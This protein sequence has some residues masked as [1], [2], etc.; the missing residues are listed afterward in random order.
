MTQFCYSSLGQKALTISGIGELMDDL[1]QA[2]TVR[3]DLLMLGGGNPAHIPEMEKVFRES[4]EDI[5]RKPGTYERCV[6]DYDG[7]RG[8]PAFLT[9]LAK[10][11]KTQY[12]WAIGPENIALTN[13]SQ[14]AFYVL[15]S[16]FAGHFADGSFHKILLPLAPEYIGYADIGFAPRQSLFAS[17]RPRME[18]LDNRQFKYHID[19]DT[20]SIGPEIGAVCVSRPT[21]P[22]GNVLTD[23]EI[24]RLRTMTRAAGVPLIIDNA[25]GLPFPG[26]LFEPATLSW[27]ENVI[28]CMSL[29]KLGLPAARTGIVVASPEVIRAISE[30]TAVMS[31]APG[32]IGPALALNL[33]QSRRI[34][35]LSQ[36]IVR[37]FYYQRMQDAVGLLRDKLDGID[38]CMHKPEGAIFLWLWFKNLPIPS[39]QLYQRL[40]QCGVLVISGHYF[41]P[42]L[43]HDDWPHKY[44]CIRITYSQ[45]ESVVQKGIQIIADEI[46]A[47]YAGA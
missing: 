22:T 17:I 35:E 24:A 23:D 2:M 6:G 37:P 9:A 20:L 18:F 43:E 26:I 39:A 12:G 27:D 13:G 19:F 3:P 33:I 10:L 31:L 36:T 11:L 16:L 32:S 8:S 29:S 42:G 46:K 7:P 45:K 40:K 47:I 15:F 34:I 21:N 4:M 30:T 14:S 25:Y 1:G 28:L 44:Q 38:Y 41:F 5:L